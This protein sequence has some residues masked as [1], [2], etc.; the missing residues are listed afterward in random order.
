MKLGEQGSR[1]MNDKL[2]AIQDDIAFLKALAEEGRAAPVA[3][4]SILV[5]AGTVFGIASL[6]H[7]TI[8]TGRIVVSAWAYPILWTAALAIFMAGL[9][10]LK[11]RMRAGMKST[12]SRASGVAWSAAG[13]TIFVMAIAITLVAIRTHSAIATML[14]P[15]LVLALYGLCWMV[16]AAVTRKRWITVT[17]VASYAAAVGL[18]W[19]A[20]T[21]A[22][23]LLYAGALVLL[24][25]APGLAL[26][27][28]GGSGDDLAANPA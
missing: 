18:A 5:L 26:M 8:A 9:A 1:L 7:W 3:G 25:V 13:W 20:D 10:V 22:V 12:A 24:A 15:S 14:L 16:A 27:R 19:F 23:F 6:A 17:A 4:G 21:P 2:Q 11:G 28:H